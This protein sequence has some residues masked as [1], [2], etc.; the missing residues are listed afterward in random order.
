MRKLVEMYGCVLDRIE[1]SHY[2]YVHSGLRRPI[3]LQKPHGSDFPPPF[4]RQ[5]LEH[6]EEIIEF[7]DEE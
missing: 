1:G 5:T 4:C 2:I 6:I 7:E 3:V